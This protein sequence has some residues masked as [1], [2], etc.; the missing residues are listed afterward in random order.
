M[1]VEGNGGGQKGFNS[2]KMDRKCASDCSK[3]P[4]AFRKVGSE[5]EQLGA[6]HSGDSRI[7][8]HRL[9]DNWHY[10]WC[11]ETSSLLD[12]VGEACFTSLDGALFPIQMLQ[13]AARRHKTPRWVPKES[14]RVL[15]QECSRL[16]RKQAVDRPISPAFSTTTRACAF[17]FDLAK[18]NDNR[19]QR[20]GAS[21]SLCD[22]RDGIDRYRSYKSKV[23]NARNRAKRRGHSTPWVTVWTAGTRD[24]QEG[25]ACPLAG[26]EVHTGYPSAGTIRTDGD[27]S[28]ATT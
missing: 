6:S 28:E 8:I 18:Q 7:C 27:G 10:E 16:P 13:K 26:V 25:P 20:N 22:I 24:T 15:W 2:R 5:R 14:S 23:R 9:G 3:H 1:G 17:F 11:L 21:Q 19:T 12:T 4:D